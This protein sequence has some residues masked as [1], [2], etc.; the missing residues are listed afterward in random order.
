MKT[1]SAIILMLT[2]FGSSMKKLLLIPMIFLV[3][4]CNAQSD[5]DS[6]KQ[7][8]L[9][10]DIAIENIHYNMRESHKEFKTGTIAIV[11]GILITAV[12]AHLVSSN[13]AEEPHVMYIGLGLTGIGS[14]LQISSHSWIGRGAWKKK[15][16]YF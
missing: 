1:L 5:Y 3:S 14:I 11:S 6:L 8:I 13:K 10:M 4:V 15:S 2:F 7:K 9:R 16:L 12:G